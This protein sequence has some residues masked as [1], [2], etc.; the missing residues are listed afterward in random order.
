MEGF[1]KN[2]KMSYQRMIAIEIERRPYFLGNGVDRYSLTMELSVLIFKVV[3]PSLLNSSE[4]GEFR[5]PR[6][7]DFSFNSKLRTLNSELQ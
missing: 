2:G 3:H 1:I 4:F 6:F 7:G 5:P